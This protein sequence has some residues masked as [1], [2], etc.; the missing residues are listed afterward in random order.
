[1]RTG[2]HA[3]LSRKKRMKKFILC[4]VGPQSTVP[5]TGLPQTSSAADIATFFFE[6]QQIYQLVIHLF[7]AAFSSPADRFISHIFSI[8]QSDSQFVHRQLRPHMH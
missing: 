7:V 8:D 2:M 1:M 3:F 4:Y 6:K 5:G